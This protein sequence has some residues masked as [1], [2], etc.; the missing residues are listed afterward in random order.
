MMRTVEIISKPVDP[1]GHVLQDDE[2]IERIEYRSDPPNGIRI[3]IAQHDDGLW[4]WSASGTIVGIYKGYR[5]GPKWGKFARTRDDA[6]AAA[7][8]EIESRN[9]TPSMLMWLE[10]LCAPA[11]LDLFA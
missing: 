7:C 6:I 10:S 5:V 11:Q 8:N 4:M 2:A 9:P 3:E 1:I